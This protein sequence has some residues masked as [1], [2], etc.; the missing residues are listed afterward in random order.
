MPAQLCACGAA[1][2]FFSLTKVH[3]QARNFDVDGE[4]FQAGALNVDHGTH[5]SAPQVRQ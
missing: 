4:K 3:F 1:S 2:V 5:S